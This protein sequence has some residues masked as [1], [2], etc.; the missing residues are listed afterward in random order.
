VQLL[1]AICMFAG[2][3]FAELDKAQIDVFKRDAAPLQAAVEEA[4][5]S[6]VPGPA[7]VLEHAKATYLEGYGVVVS[8]EASLEPTR[9]PF[10]S[11]KTPSEIRT[12]VAQRRKAVQEKLETLLKE[13]TLKMQSIGETEA[14]TIAFHL[15][16]SNPADLPNLPS[17]V[18]FTVKKQDPT[19]VIIQEF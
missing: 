3:A 9:T 7:G 4:I 18:V 17:Q 5:N 11:P 15:F 14:L 10:S 12:I 13:R 19:H 16:N 2:M 8:V 1:F 6:V